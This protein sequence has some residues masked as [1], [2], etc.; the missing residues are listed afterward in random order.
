MSIS[1]CVYVFDFSV[2]GIE[3]FEK[4]VM[5]SCQGIKKCSIRIKWLFKLCSNQDVEHIGC[6]LSVNELLVLRRLIALMHHDRN[7][8]SNLK[9]VMDLTLQYTHHGT[10]HS[11]LLCTLMFQTEVLIYITTQDT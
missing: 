1:V 3:I 6:F 5:L 11:L 9:A 10:V 7:V 8:H 4:R 2:G